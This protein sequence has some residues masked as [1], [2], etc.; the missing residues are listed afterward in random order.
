MGANAACCC[1]DD[2]AAARYDAF[3]AD[4][5]LGY[6]LDET[7]GIPVIHKGASSCAIGADYHTRLQLE[8]EAAKQAAKDGL[9][10][11]KAKAEKRQRKAEE[12]ANR[13]EEKRKVDEAAREAKRR[14]DIETA[15]RER[16]HERVAAAE[17][18]HRNKV[19][20]LVKEGNALF[21]GRE[22]GQAKERFSAA[23][24]IDGGAIFA[25]AG[26]GACH[27]RL[28]DFAASL[29]D[30]DKA[31][32]LEPVQMYAIRDRAEVRLRLGDLDGSIAD[33]DAK[34]AMTAIDGKA[35]C[36]RGEAKL[37]QGKKQGAVADFEMAIKLR[38]SVPND[39][40]VQARAG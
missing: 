27:L 26:R 38:H 40:L 22:F 28:S 3:A 1:K 32:E 11:E 8:R 14:A 15:K 39:L 31:L 25:W 36:G 4:D 2:L 24:V 10:E 13:A 5:A 7:S 12:A 33:Y 29:A 17:Q 34:L 21:D 23:L 9:R 19:D 18:Q 16:E 37:L 6:A 30:L 20:Q 35:F